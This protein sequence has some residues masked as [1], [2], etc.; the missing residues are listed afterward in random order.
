MKLIKLICL[1]GLLPASLTAQ[2]IQSADF[3]NPDFK[4]RRQGATSGILNVSVNTAKVEG[5]QSSGS[6]TWRHSAGG[7]AQVRTNVIVANLDAQ[8]AAYTQTS[9]DS[10]VFGREITTS[11]TLLGEDVGGQNL[12]PL[13]NDLVGASVLYSWESDATMS[14]LAIAPNQVYEVSF[15]VTSGS[16]LPANLLSASTFGITNPE[17]SG[18]GAGSAELLNL[19]DVVT[20]GNQPDTGLFTF[21][22]QSSQALDHLDFKF[23]ATSGVS[24][25]ALGGSA[26]N[27]NVLTFSEFTVN[28][29]PEP[30]SLMLSGLLGGVCLLRR[31]R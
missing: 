24:V 13:I 26:E 6:T 7:H 21:Q 20:L 2:T 12:T 29:V 9:G 1:A 30:S 15:R 8:L 4:V 25:S 31:R 16:G 17:V 5:T 27:Q 10:L 19:L 14:G 11:A 18:T 28:Q 22:F 23:A 3:F